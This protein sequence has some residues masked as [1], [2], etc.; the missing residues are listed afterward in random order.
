MDFKLEMLFGC[1]K[2]PLDCIG[3]WATYTQ[4]VCLYVCMSGIMDLIHFCGAGSPYGSAAGLD[5]QPMT[6]IL[7]EGGGGVVAINNVPTKYSMTKNYLKKTD[8]VLT[9]Q[10]SDL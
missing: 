2:N 6:G 4:D 8:W 9:V 7:S 1:K 10:T 5:R 3:M